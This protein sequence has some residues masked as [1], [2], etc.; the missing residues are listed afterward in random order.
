MPSD[1]ALIAVVIGGSGSHPDGARDPYLVDFP[2]SRV[3]FDFR[4][5][6]YAKQKNRSRLEL[7]GWF[8]ELPWP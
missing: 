8:H 7:A 3:T 2:R 5:R 4:T 1:N 6:E